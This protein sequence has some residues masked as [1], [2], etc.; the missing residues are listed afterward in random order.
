MDLTQNQSWPIRLNVADAIDALSQ[1]HSLFLS[2]YT[3]NDLDAENDSD[4]IGGISRDDIASAVLER[5]SR[6][7]SRRNLDFIG[8]YRGDVIPMEISLG[9]LAGEAL[10]EVRQ[11]SDFLAEHV[12]QMLEGGASNISDISHA[13]LERYVELIHEDEDGALLIALFDRFENDI[14]ALVLEHDIRPA[15]EDAISQL[16]DES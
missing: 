4:N 11:Q 10:S 3:R 14:M 9:G 6:A 13:L 8:P 16:E 2:I 5:V 15:V 12:D 1:H 7:A